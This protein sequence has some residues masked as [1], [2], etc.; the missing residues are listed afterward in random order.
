MPNITDVLV[1]NWANNRART[2][3]DKFMQLSYDMQAYVADYGTAGIA[4]AL[5]ADGPTGLIQDG[6]ATD[7]RTPVVGTDLQN[8]IAGINQIVTAFGT[9]ITGVGSP[10]TTVAGKWQVN[11]TPR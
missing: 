11:G 10:I 5:V 9:A 1:I 6:S 3:A 7:G 2:I 4:A 8:L